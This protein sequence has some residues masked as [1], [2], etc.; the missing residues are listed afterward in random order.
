M[1]WEN[2]ESE[3]SRVWMDLTAQ[4]EPKVR[5]VT[6]A[7]KDRQERRDQSVCPV[8]KVYSVITERVGRKEHSVRKGLKV[9]RV[10][11][12]MPERMD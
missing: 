7:A 8:A 9:M 11:R 4:R 5:R 6:R 10:Q 12:E 3:V 1:Y 2:R